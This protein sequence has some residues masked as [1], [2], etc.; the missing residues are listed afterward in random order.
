MTM[1]STAKVVMGVASRS[2]DRDSKR[3]SSAPPQ[4]HHHDDERTASS[5]AKA[6]TGCVDCIIS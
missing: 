3:A 6:Q 5:V 4:H 2:L 1:L